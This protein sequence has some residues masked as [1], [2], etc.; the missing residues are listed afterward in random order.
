[1]PEHDKTIPFIKDPEFD[2]GHIFSGDRAYL[3]A[4]SGPNSGKIYLLKDGKNLAGR[5]QNADIYLDDTQVSRKHSEFIY[6]DGETSVEDLESTNGTLVNGKKISSKV[7]LKEG[8]KVAIGATA[9]T[10]SISTPIEASIKGLMGHSQF[11]RR[12]YE[13]LDRASRYKRPLCVMMVALDFDEGALKKEGKE[14]DKLKK[15]KLIELVDYIKGLIRG[16]DI[17]AFYGRFEIEL[18]LPETGKKDAMALAQRIQKMAN[19]SKSVILSI[20]ISSY[21]EDSKSKDFLIDKSRQALKTAKQKDKDKIVETKE[22]VKTIVVSDRKIIIKSDKMIQL[23]DLVDRIAKSNISVLI[24]GETGV[25][26]EVIAEAIHYKSDRSDKPL[27]SVNCAAL[28]ET[29][30][31]SELFGYEKGSFTGADHQKIGLFESAKGGTIFLDEIGEMPTKTQAK[32]L[33]VLQS[34]KIMR[35]GG[36]KEIPIDVRV[37]AATNKNL[38]DSIKNGTFREDLYFR[39]NAITINIPPLRERK[40]EI[41][42]LASAFV[43]VCAKENG[44]GE[45]TI[46]PVALGMLSQYEWPGNVRELKNCIER[47]SVVAAESII[48]LEDLAL[49]ISVG[50]KPL[51]TVEESGFTV[52]QSIMSDS[53]KGLV[54]NYEKDLLFDVLKKTNFNQT[55]AADILKIPRRTLVSKLRKYKIKKPD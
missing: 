38:E 43:I 22:D 37:I 6:D 36:N 34:K 3:T 32:L 42:D 4:I 14:T 15:K 9:F 10:Y 30:L 50:D 16:M 7:A 55:K 11:E 31:E 21:P 25:G 35:V 17:I 1:M 24:Q 41:P 13:E 5:I 53:M 48:S 46:D 52:T 19:T 33:R 54:E 27:I 28:T 12:L 20:G 49:K 51:Q 29:I 26:K 18:M 44:R 39:L 2:D 8:D 45:M 47:A 40:E 23:F